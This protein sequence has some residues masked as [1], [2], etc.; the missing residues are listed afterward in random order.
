M[1][2]ELQLMLNEFIDRGFAVGEMLDVLYCLHDIEEYR[3]I[4]EIYRKREMYTELIHYQNEEE[5]ARFMANKTLRK[6]NLEYEI[7]ELI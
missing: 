5:G 1:K 7:D 2:Q 3:H 6:Y 4:Q